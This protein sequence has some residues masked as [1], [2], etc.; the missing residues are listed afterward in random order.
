[1][2]FDNMVKRMVSLFVLEL[3][4]TKDL[5]LFEDSCLE[6]FSL[7]YESGKR[8]QKDENFKERL[9]FK[10]DQPGSPYYGTSAC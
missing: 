8:Q 3:E 9:K 5:K 7:G 6:F 4:G 2:F 1:M 10:S